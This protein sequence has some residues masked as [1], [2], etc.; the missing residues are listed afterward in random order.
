MSQ[1]TY[2]IK[3]MHCASCE[4]IIEKKL[5]KLENVQ[6]AD[7]SMST[8]QLNLSYLQNPPSN[9]E[10]NLIFKDEGYV[11]SNTPFANQKFSFKNLL[12]PIIFSVLI[13]IAFLI[14][15]KMGLSS[16][17]NVN[18]DSSVLAFFV[19]G[20]IAGVS[21]CAALIG[22]LILSFSK[23][24]SKAYSES[25]SILEKSKPNFLFNAGRLISYALFGLFLGLLGEKLNISPTFTSF[26]VVIVS[27]IMAILALQMLGVKAFSRFRFALP[28]QFTN[29]I[30][31][32]DDSKGKIA[33]FGIGFLTVF[34]PCGFTVVA[35]GMAILSGNPI[36]G[37]M[38]MMFFALGTAIPL[39]FIG[40]F[41]AKLMENK[42]V[43]DKFLK[44][45]GILII[46][47]IIFNLNTQFGFTAM[48][49]QSPEPE[50]NN[51]ISN[52]NV[53]EIK[54]VYTLDSDIIPSSFTVKI[55]QPIKFV[56]DSKNNGIGCMSTIMV[57]GLYDRPIYLK[58][59]K[60]IVMEFTPK[61]AGTYQ[62]TCAMGVPR[63]TIIVTN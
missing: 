63:G 34:L 9:D 29:K 32:S 59:D 48:F 62:I 16:F 54:T 43:S 11:F 36:Q 6:F 19:F 45:A 51:T 27:A 39:M 15:T 1:K 7:A 46:F 40:T 5:L 28:K 38:I 60:Q 12:W 53:Q 44:V 14:L 52:E 30:A 24:W 3:G 33:P 57:P 20:L 41:S 2:Y 10:L 18:S 4:V 47:F 42:K 58:K 26:L 55:N 49:N 8:G 61:K 22:G 25:N 17:I 35:E 21:S 31:K 50:Q 23:N 13:I 37:S 56:V